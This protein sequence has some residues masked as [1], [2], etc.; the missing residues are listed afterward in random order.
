MRLSKNLRGGIILDC[1]GDLVLSKSDLPYLN[2]L[3]KSD[4][5]GVNMIAGCGGFISNLKAL[6]IVFRW[7]FFNDLSYLKKNGKDFNEIFNK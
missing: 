3:E 5:V 2:Y 6:W 4:I 1:R 7:L